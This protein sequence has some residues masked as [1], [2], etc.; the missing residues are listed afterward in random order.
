M[1]KLL[2]FIT[3]SCLAV[4]L[5]SISVN[6]TLGAPSIPGSSKNESE[7]EKCTEDYNEYNHESIINS[8]KCIIDYAIKTKDF[9]VCE[10][11]WPDKINKYLKNSCIDQFSLRYNDKEL[12]EK[13]TKASETTSIENKKYIC[14]ERLNTDAISFEKCENEI[15]TE[16]Q[17]ECVFFLARLNNEPGLC[18][19]IKSDDVRKTCLEQYTPEIYKQEKS[20][21]QLKQYCDGVWQYAD[22]SR[23]IGDNC[24]TETALQYNNPEFC[25]ISNTYIGFVGPCIEKVASKNND[26]SMCNAIPVETNVQEGYKMR[27]FTQVAIDN[28]NPEA[29][30]SIEE[31]E[32]RASCIV[33][34]AE[35][36]ENGTAC[37]LIESEISKKICIA[38]VSDDEV[39]EVSETSES[40][41][42]EKSYDCGSLNVK[43]CLIRL[44]MTNDDPSYCDEIE[45]EFGNAN[46]LKSVAVTSKI[47]E[48]C[49]ELKKESE[50]SE[51]L[52][53]FRITQ[54]ECLKNAGVEYGS[55][56]TNLAIFI[57][58]AVFIISIGIHIIIFNRKIGI[59]LVPII[60][61]LTLG[62]G[63]MIG[64]YKLLYTV[65]F[66]AHFFE[67]IIILNLSMIGVNFLYNSVKQRGVNT[68]SYYI[69][70]ILGILVPITLPLLRAF[71]DRGPVGSFYIKSLGIPMELLS[72][73]GH[74]AIAGIP[75]LFCIYLLIKIKRRMPHKEGVSAIK[76]AMVLLLLGALF[77]IAVLFSPFLIV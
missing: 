55:K 67:L 73:F 69:L 29:C 21:E 39:D 13:F 6:F 22:S 49:Y 12:C 72:H 5:F 58:L 64:D 31:G 65:G 43:D 46:C 26:P 16:V 59:I 32:R 61:L 66:F 28:N 44:A 3:V 52:K 77:D 38:N 30:L 76:I 71:T 34:V 10:R 60:G 23:V 54:E 40:Y 24:V 2:K 53:M 36:Y 25:K 9:T 47:P 15:V 63:E 62:A 4:I 8:R 14:Y 68:L 1:K 33:D 56:N 27:C 45:D 17:S 42:S 19:A 35:K 70:Y 57:L 51:Q 20:T 7:L 50:A 75:F 11:E 74:V 41:S 18:F 37:D 48:I